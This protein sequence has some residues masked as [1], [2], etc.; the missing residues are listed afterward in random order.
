MLL[1]EFSFLRVGSKWR[2]FVNTVINE[3]SGFIKGWEFLYQRI[4]YQ[5][6]KKD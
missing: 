1:T 4:E 3:P 5:F 2:A 6:L